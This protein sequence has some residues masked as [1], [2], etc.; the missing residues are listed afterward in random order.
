MS[1]QATKVK[2]VVKHL[3][4]EMLCPAHP[5]ATASKPAALRFTGERHGWIYAVINEIRGALILGGEN[6]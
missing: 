2:A 5:A 6:V 4:A 1:W 3:N